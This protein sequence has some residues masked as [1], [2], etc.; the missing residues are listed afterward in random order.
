MAGRGSRFANVGVNTPKPL[1]S[2]LGQPMLAWALKS[3][4]GLTLSEVFFIAL[5]EHQEKFLI[6]QT[7]RAICPWPFQLIL[8]DD[9]TE[10]QLCT[11]LAARQFID[12]EDDLLISSSD[13]Y[14]VS[15]LAESI[16]EKPAGCH[17]IISVAAIPG[18]RWSFA[19][20]DKMGNVI[21]VAEKTRISDHASTGMYYF[22]KGSEFVEE[23]ERMIKNQEKTRGEYYVIPLYQKLIALGYQIRISQETEVWDMGNP[24]ALRSF[25]QHLASKN[26]S[27]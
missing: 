12:G 25:E 14:V 20:V 21:E 15:N 2:V 5:K 9:V 7:L 18:E 26:E 10:G 6:D 3:L 19:R 23:A 22:S 16:E 1:I 27:K 24:D 17:G 11:V 4:E 8:I 13:T